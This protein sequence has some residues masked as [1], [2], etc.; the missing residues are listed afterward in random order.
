MLTVQLLAPDEMTQDE[1]ERVIVPESGALQMLPFHVI[2]VA[3]LAVAV[4]LANS[5]W[6]L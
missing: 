5:I 2:P 6:L 1:A 3:Q 4:L